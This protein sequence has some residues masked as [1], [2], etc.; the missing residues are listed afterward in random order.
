[1]DYKANL[2]FASSSTQLSAQALASRKICVGKLQNLLLSAISQ[3]QAIP[4]YCAV[5]VEY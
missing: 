1:M 3:A 2:C 4:Q 5:I